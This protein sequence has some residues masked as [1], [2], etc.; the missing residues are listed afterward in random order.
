MMILNK[1][2]LSKSLYS[3]W[4]TKLFVVPRELEAFLPKKEQTILKMKANERSNLT[5]SNYD[6]GTFVKVSLSVGNEL[7]TR[8]LACLILFRSELLI[9]F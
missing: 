6:E 8:E 4:Q 7:S 1:A 9:P 3:A 2:H 5:A